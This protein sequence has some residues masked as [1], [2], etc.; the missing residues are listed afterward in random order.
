M[1]VSVL[2]IHACP[3]GGWKK[4]PAPLELELLTALSHHVGV[5]NR[6]CVLCKSSKS[7]TLWAI[8]PASM[9]FFFPFWDKV[10]LG[11]SDWSRTLQLAQ[12]S[13][14][15]EDISASHSSIFPLDYEWLIHIN[16][17]PSLF[18]VS[19]S[20]NN[21]W[22]LTCPSQVIKMKEDQVYKGPDSKYS[23]H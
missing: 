7:L 20:F 8:F 14:K 4:G 16:K 17:Y 1:Y 11:S 22:I 15:L 18:T 2:C 12:A 23:I 3:W 6:T 13:F 19:F 5:R 9:F 21:M 10:L